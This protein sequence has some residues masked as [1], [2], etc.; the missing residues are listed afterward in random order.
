MHRGYIKFWRKAQD[1]LSWNRGLMYQGL[2]INFL[3]RAAWQKNCYQG[4]NILPGQFGVVL[5]H[6]AKELGLTRST[7]Q[8][9]L[10]HLEADDFL[11]IENVG[12][13]FVLITIINWHTY[14]TQEKE[15]GQQSPGGQQTGAH[16]Y[17][18]LATEN[19][20]KPYSQLGNMDMDT[21]KMG[22][23][24][25]NHWATDD[26]PPEQPS[27]IEKEIRKRN[28]KAQESYD[29]SPELSARDSGKKSGELAM[30]SHGELEQPGD[31]SPGND[32]AKHE[33]TARGEEIEPASHM[34]KKYTEKAVSLTKFSATRR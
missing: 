23:S 9:M 14:Q 31:V 34:P 24:L 26:R 21:S 25:V 12:N 18:K 16:V 4:R 11:K 10:A 33:T 15:N 1:S 22:N 27:Y 6:L 30:N 5:T 2:I 3:S 20:L 19:Q 7:L 28:I 8:R 29:S 13:R 17:E 32:N